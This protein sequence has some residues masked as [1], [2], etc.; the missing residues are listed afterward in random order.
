MDMMISISISALGLSEGLR[1]DKN[2]NS[3]ASKIAGLVLQA[4]ERKRKK[5]SE[6]TFHL[7]AGGCSLALIIAPCFALARITHNISI[8]A[9]KIS[10]LYVG[11]IIVGNKVRESYSVKKIIEACNRLFI[12]IGRG[13][14]LA[15]DA[16]AAIK[17]CI[18]HPLE[19]SKQTLKLMEQEFVATAELI[20]KASSV[21]FSEAILSQDTRS[22][23]EDAA[24]MDQC[25]VAYRESRQKLNEEI[26]NAAKT[27]RSMEETFTLEVHKSGASV[28]T[29]E[30]V[31]QLKEAIASAHVKAQNLRQSLNDLDRIAEGLQVAVDSI[32]KWHYFVLNETNL[33]VK[34]RLIGGFYDRQLLGELLAMIPKDGSNPDQKL[35]S[36]KQVYED[37]GKL[38]G[39]K[40]A[41]FSKKH[42]S[43]EQKLANL[44]R[45]SQTFAT[46]K[47]KAV[48]A[49][50]KNVNEGSEPSPLFSPQDE[51]KLQR[52][53]DDSKELSNYF[54][55][56]GLTYNE[57][58][59]STTKQLIAS[60]LLGGPLL[61]DY[62]VR[63]LKKATSTFSGQIGEALGTI[64]TEMRSLILNSGQKPTTEIEKEA[65]SGMERIS[66]TQE[67]YKKLQDKVKSYEAD[68]NTVVDLEAKI[69]ELD[70]K[71]DLPDNSESLEKLQT[72]R[73]LTKIY[74]MVH[75]LDQNRFFAI[76]IVAEIS[77]GIRLSAPEE[78]VSMFYA[79][80]K[81]KKLKNLPS[82][83]TDYTDKDMLEFYHKIAHSGDRFT[84]KRQV[85]FQKSRTFQEIKQLIDLLD[86]WREEE[87]AKSQKDKI[88]ARMIAETDQLNTCLRDTREDIRTLIETW[89]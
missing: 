7:L 77:Q 89:I 76:K 18:I 27:I 71:Q 10:A 66:E 15:I 88:D 20:K 57:Q 46:E 65:I 62:G 13:G 45:D 58:W 50:L 73:Y 14:A 26:E 23:L 24:Q 37:T 69:H 63:T 17:E 34:E 19:S 31:V 22:V 41:D 8:A 55:S 70:R 51:E 83:Y 3:I 6:Y 4:S 40:R 2:S 54:E 48:T 81:R 28:E 68:F 21:D 43:A 35:L 87:V 42:R 16:I 75:K 29:D 52:W 25:L 72:I 85:M 80:D 86:G 82:D 74:E 79:P 5:V 33:S 60:A 61:M 56:N 12:L 84:K 47:I 49:N 44:T 53:V 67:L 9:L 32:L 39:M 1:Q 30:T 38:T 36:L 78:I 11:G 64:T 59:L